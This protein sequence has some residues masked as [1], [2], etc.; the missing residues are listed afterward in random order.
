MNPK[1]S[2]SCW[3]PSRLAFCVAAVFGVIP[4]Q[5]D[6]TWTAQTRTLEA[7]AEASVGSVVDGPWV[8]LDDAS[9]FGVFD[10]AVEPLAVAFLGRDIAIVQGVANQ[11]SVL[12]LSSFVARGEASVSMTLTPVVGASGSATGSSTFEV[13]FYVGEPSLFSLSGVLDTQAIL[14]GG[15]SVP[16]LDNEVGLERTDDNTLI[17]E[18]G[19]NDTVL[20]EAGPLI[21]GNYRFWASAEVD[22]SQASIVSGPRTVA[23]ISEFDLQLM[24]MGIP[25]TSTYLSMLGLA[26]VVSLV[27]Y[28]RVRA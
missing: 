28:R 19:S 3:L 20:A 12:G 5:A 7:S 11:Y 25:E 10:S 26:G 23:G 9:D 16:F 21:P 22:A 15:A 6:V 4:S 8:G 18:S 24:V 1:A 27:G 17:F 14:T 2:F 13:R